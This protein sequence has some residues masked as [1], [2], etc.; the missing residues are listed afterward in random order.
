M[1]AAG[2]LEVRL[3]LAVGAS[4]F[5]GTASG[6]KKRK[7]SMWVHASLWVSTTSSVAADP[8]RSG[9]RSCRCSPGPTL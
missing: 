8:R 5:R 2:L 4:A 9:R 7:A 3:G 6:V 1:Q